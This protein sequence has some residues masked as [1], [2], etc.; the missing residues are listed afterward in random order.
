MANGVEA[1]PGTNA[2]DAYFPALT[3]VRAVAAYCVY[4]YHFS[5]F[6]PTNWGGI[7]WRLTQEL[8][9]GVPLFY[10]LSGFLIR[11]R[12][13]EERPTRW[14]AYA[15][16]RWGRIYPAYYL[17]LFLAYFVQGTPPVGL[18][19]VHLTLTQGF[20]PALYRTGIGQAFTLTVEESFYF[21]APFLFGIA[22]RVPLWL[23]AFAFFGAGVAGLIATGNSFWLSST[24]LGAMPCFAAGMWLAR[25][26]RWENRAPAKGV[27]DT[28]LGAMGIVMVVAALAFLRSEGSE[29]VAYALVLFVV[30]PL[31][32]AWFYR[33]LLREGTPLRTL[34]ANPWVGE[35]GKSSYV[36]YLIHM[37]VIHDFLYDCVTANYWARF[38]LLNGIAVAISV[39][40]ERPMTTL[41]GSL[42]G[43][44]VAQEEVGRQRRRATI[45]LRLFGVAIVLVGVLGSVGPWQPR[46]VAWYRAAHGAGR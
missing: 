12:Y 20:F 29:S 8:H 4:F 21:L 31:A 37:G 10:V 33:G 17:V 41:I 23:I 45:R 28:V 42:A 19:L 3:G 13:G 34:L 2:R 30:L 11:H 44:R 39:G 27:R 35:L 14:S 18:L 6:Q 38:I 9:I 22:R 36:F 43:G 7:P 25:G 26:E 15:L 5:P 24:L 16:R 1:P 40:F 32:V 46:L